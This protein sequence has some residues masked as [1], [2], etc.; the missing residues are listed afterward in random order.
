M[1]MS[2]TDRGSDTTL[3]YTPNGRDN[4][5]AVATTRGRVATFGD[6]SDPIA[7]A[8]AAAHSQKQGQNG[9]AA[10]HAKDAPSNGSL[11]KSSVAVEATPLPAPV[12][13]SQGTLNFA[14]QVEQVRKNSAQRRPRMLRLTPAFSSAPGT[15]TKSLDGRS[16]F[17]GGDVGNTTTAIPLH[18][19]SRKALALKAS[20]PSDAPPGLQLDLACL[21]VPTVHDSMNAA[22]TSTLP[23]LVRKKSGEPVKSSLKHYP[24]S[25]FPGRADSMDEGF[26]AR[27]KSV[28]T[29]PTIAK[30]VHFGDELEHIKL[31]KHKQRP[32][33]VSR[34]GSP[35][36]T[37]TE[38][39][40]ERDF[41]FF[42][43]S[44]K[45]SDDVQKSQ[46]VP[47]EDKSTQA[48]VE[49]Q[50]VL[51]LP[52]FP[53][54]TR[55]SVERDIFL[56][57]VFLADDLRSVKGTIQ[58]RNIAFEKWVAVRFTL[59]NWA[60]VNEVSAEFSESIKSGSADRFVFSIK[61]NELLNWP[62]GAGQHETKSMFLCIRFRTSGS[63]IWDNNEGQNYQ[64][65][66]RK[67][68]APTPA[69]ADSRA[70]TRAPQRAAANTSSAQGSRAMQ[71]LEMGRKGVSGMSRPGHL[72][73]EELKRELS[74]LTSDEEDGDHQLR[75]VALRA[76]DRSSPPTSPGN[77][78]GSP[79]IWSARYDF[80]ESL[81]NPTLGSRQHGS[82]R[83]SA[84]DYFSVAYSRPGAMIMPAR[85]EAPP[86]QHLAAPDAAGHRANFR[87]DGLSQTSG[88]LGM[89]SPGLGA[90]MQHEAKSSV[91][92][93]PELTPSG[94]APSKFYVSAGLGLRLD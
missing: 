11:P 47:K 64:L 62:R 33:A 51:R 50:L 34:D 71:F 88:R 82:S 45:P 79:S 49:E 59:D 54:S 26:S 55:L 63:E 24:V 3:H 42:A 5:S 81:K 14:A 1:V 29:T 76:P 75:P 23:D 17:P 65:D 2:R 73:M 16:S 20:A 27:A 53:S 61:L 38:T 72:M 35:E 18:P 80:G 8:P 36:Q 7:G 44:M 84:P 93:S 31:F 68:L 66:F 74:R 83:S 15:L 70:Q 13:P 78:S 40:E 22:S 60:T 9:K 46:A 25:A 30:A 43:L 89:L 37:E 57:R 94:H 86:S 69:A 21:P 4:T 90:M 10:S 77:R 87:V 39:E 92:P 48:A 56:E 52:N 19:N 91:S 67:R 28:P 6:N 12:A 41:P 85:K 58:V 32:S